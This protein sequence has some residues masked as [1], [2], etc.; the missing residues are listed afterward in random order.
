M[1]DAR[2]GA[3]KGGHTP[4]PWTLTR[5][6]GL[7][8]GAQDYAISAKGASVLSEAYGRGALGEW[9]PAEANARL[10]AAAPDLVTAGKHLAVKLAEVYRAAGRSPAECQAIR[11]WM[12][13]LA[14]SEGRQP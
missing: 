11:D 12:A 6:P 7:H 3:G 13:A 9:L 2:Q 4:G 14:L 8:D 5:S 10:I 1:T